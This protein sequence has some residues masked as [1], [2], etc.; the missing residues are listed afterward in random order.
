MSANYLNVFTFF[1][2][3]LNE[4][5][6]QRK[7]GIEGGS[8][9]KKRNIYTNER[10]KEKQFIETKSWW[11]C[12]IFVCL[13]HI[14]FPLFFSHYCTINPNSFF[15]IASII[16]IWETQ[17][18]PHFTSNANSNENRRNVAKETNKQQ[19]RQNEI[20]YWQIDRQTDNKSR[21][22]NRECARVCVCKTHCVCKSCKQAMKDG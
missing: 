5:R 1:S 4:K 2:Y 16:A 11:W 14:I 12:L 13:L 3:M 15:E 8:T 9:A 17:T 19:H 7:D 21:I 6:N 20:P 22:T 18:H 10:K